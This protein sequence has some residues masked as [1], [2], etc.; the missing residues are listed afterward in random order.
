VEVCVAGAVSIGG[1]SGLIVV[2]AA[3]AVIV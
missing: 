2:V 3:V 1:V